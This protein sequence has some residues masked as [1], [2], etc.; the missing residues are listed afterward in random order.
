M[1]VL[2]PLPNL[3]ALCML[4]ALQQAKLRLKGV[5][6]QDE[7]K[8]RQGEQKP[9]NKEGDKGEKRQVAPLGI[10]LNLWR[11]NTPPQPGSSPS[12]S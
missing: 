11:F 8:E 2:L 3:S 6:D 12:R 9:Q 4:T 1:I 7:Q 5:D 10:E